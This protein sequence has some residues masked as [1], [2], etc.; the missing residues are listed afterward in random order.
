MNNSVYF[1]GIRHHGPGS[2]RSLLEA[3]EQLQPDCLL[4][5]GP[6]E[7]DKILEHVGDSAMQP[8]IAMLNYVKDTPQQAVF[9]PFAIYSPEWQALQYGS[10]QQIAMRFMDLPLAH[11]FAIRQAEINQLA[12][13]KVE[14]SA[15]EVTPLSVEESN[16]EALEA[17][18]APAEDVVGTLPSWHRDPLAQLARAAGYSDGE[19]WWGHVVEERLESN[20]VFQAVHEAM[21][22]L[23]EDVGGATFEP[24]NLSEARREASMRKIIRK[25][26]KDGFERIA[27]ICG[28]W[29]VPAL[30]RWQAKGQ[31]TA[32]NKILKGLPKVSVKSTWIPY[33]TGRLAK[34]SGYGAGISS[35]GWYAHLWRYGKKNAGTGDETGDRT[36]DSAVRWLARVAQLLREQDIMASSAQV[37]DAVRLAE[38]L[39]AIRGRAVVGLDELNEAA[40][41]VFANGNPLILRLIHDKLIIAD[42]LGSV[43]DKVPATPLQL[44]LQAQQ[45]RLRFKA[46]AV[47]KNIELDLRKENDLARSKLLYRLSLLEIPWGKRSHA[48]STGTFKEAW[49]L[50]WQ[51]EYTL[52]LI[53]AGRYGQTVA[54]ASSEKV[55]QACQQAQNIAQLS[56]LL[57]ET[58][59]ADL[60]EASQFLLQQL[61]DKAA[62]D[63]D[64]NHL[65]LALPKLIHVLRYGNVR[66]NLHHDEVT[67]SRASN[68]L[69]AVRQV[70][71][72]M[73]S[74]ICIGLPNACHAIADDAAQSLFEQVQQVQQ[75]LK[76]LEDEAMLGEWLE[77]LHI[78]SQREQSHPLLVGRSLKIRLDE[79][80]I[81]SEKAAQALGLALSDSEVARAATWLE[82]FLQ[83]GALLLIHDDSMFK[84]LDSWLAALSPENFTRVLPLLR[85]TFSSFASPEKEAIGR[86]AKRGKKQVMK[87]VL[88][89]DDAR[90]TAMLEHLAV[91]LGTKKVLTSA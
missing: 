18:F 79:G 55:K 35:P 75:A 73:F 70:V 22:A 66:T 28:A 67:E 26:V 6:P 88:E 4:I 3:L 87:Q 34:Q 49:L 40:E 57:D 52:Q 47:E 9:D 48:S 42:V 10:R 5:E 17:D 7:G 31:S 25:A 12:Q 60:P 86:K 91:L 61:D 14:E 33:T 71:T 15:D 90:A 84:V 50:V 11:R 45:K 78:I 63:N 37:I 51:P 2:A 39:A 54:Q 36:G 20:D 46:S 8:P 16:V 85:R 65:M 89:V 74:R 1:F 80:V 68:E 64:I 38:S 44:D 41:A 19:R 29:H 30:Q 82:G 59:L 27:V 24:E 43:S 21:S 58:L 23:R 62:E 72:G 53:E 77:T 81:T 56:A 76:I 69:Q 83:D 13:E 32:D